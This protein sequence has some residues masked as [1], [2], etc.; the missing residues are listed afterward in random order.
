MGIK[1]AMQT[2]SVFFMSKDICNFFKL[3]FIESN[4]KV[5]FFCESNFIFEYLEFYIY[6]HSMEKNNNLV[7][8]T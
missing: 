7:C 1:K 6:L 5:G 8:L 3:K 2:N 4:Y